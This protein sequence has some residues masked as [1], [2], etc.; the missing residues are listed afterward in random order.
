MSWG[1]LLSKYSNKSDVIFGSV[2]SGRPVELEGI[3]QMVGLFINTLPVRIRYEEDSDI[4]QLLQESQKKALEAEP[5]SCYPL[6]SI[7]SLTK[8]GKDL[9]DHIIVFENYPMSAY[10]ERDNDYTISNI[11]VFDQ[12]NYD[13]M[14]VVIP[15]REFKIRFNYNANVYNDDLILQSSGHLK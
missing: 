10:L 2:V 6:R 5:Y 7:Q 14:L 15:E 12:V 8:L 9:F 3:E 4:T 11:Q 13:L 1:I